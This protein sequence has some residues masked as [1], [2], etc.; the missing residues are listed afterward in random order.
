MI[1]RLPIEHIVIDPEKRRGKPMID[2]TGITVQDIAD[3]LHNGL[4][5]EQIAD[6]FDLTLGEVHAA[7]S[8]YHDHKAEIDAARQ[9]DKSQAD[10]QLSE[11]EK[12]GQAVSLEALKR[13]IEARKR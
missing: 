4:T 2:G 5:P 1:T 10:A 3:S 12:K 11:L 8:Y 6:E 13:R 7:L 9:D